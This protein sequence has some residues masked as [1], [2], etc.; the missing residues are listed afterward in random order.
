MSTPLNGSVLKAF[1]I[2]GLFSKARPEITANTVASELGTNVATAH[3]FL[4]TLEAAGALVSYRRGCF[5]LGGTIEELGRL[6]ESVNPIAT[7]VQPIINEVSRDIRESVMVCRLGRRG[8]TCI[9]VAVSDQ[10]ISVK[11]DVGTVLP[12]DVTA[13][14]KLWLAHMSKPDQSNWLKDT[15]QD[16]K[17]ALTKIKAQGFALNQG[18]NEPDLGAVAVPVYGDDGKLSMTISVFGML[19]RFNAP[20]IERSVASLTHAAKAIG[21]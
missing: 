11:V 5:A 9:A 1:S 19:S 14:G 2:L 4:L 10:P 15:T 7:K 18:D 20:L 12:I 21:A 13:H 6:A 16:L 8:P 3:R 17:D